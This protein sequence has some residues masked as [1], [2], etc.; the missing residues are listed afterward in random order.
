MCRMGA[1]ACL[2]L[3]S[4][5]APMQQ[6]VSAT[7]SEA[8]SLAKEEAATKATVEGFV[9]SYRASAT[10]KAEWGDAKKELDWIAAFEG[11]FENEKALSYRGKVL[12]KGTHEMWVETGKAEWLYLV[13]GNRKDDKAPRIR[14]MFRIYGDQKEGVEKINFELKLRR[15]KTKLKFSIRAGKSEAHGNLNILPEESQERQAMS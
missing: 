7:E 10:P 12:P 4:L 11:K 8:P 6:L 13:I 1:F 5:L 15:K 2:F 14:A 9:G 3:V